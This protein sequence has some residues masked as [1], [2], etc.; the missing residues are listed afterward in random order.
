MKNQNL[1]FSIKNMGLSEDSEAIQLLREMDEAEVLEMTL[2]ANLNIG[3]LI[4]G[5]QQYVNETGAK[6]TFWEFVV[7][8]WDWMKKR[9]LIQKQMQYN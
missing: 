2:Y 5:F 9:S 6:I 8:T 3:H 4:L 7:G 1:E